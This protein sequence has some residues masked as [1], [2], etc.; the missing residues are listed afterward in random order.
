MILPCKRKSTDKIAGYA[1]KEPVVIPTDTLYGLSMSI[2]GPI[3]RIFELK[4]RN[5]INKIP[6]GVLN[7]DM[8]RKIAYVSP[9][10]IK[11]VHEFMP[12]PLTIVLESKIPQITGETVGVRIPNHVIPLWLM[13]KIGPV[14]L[15]SANIS[16]ET[17]PRK[18]EDTMHL[19]VKYRINC[20]ALPGIPSTV[21]S[22]VN[23]V[24]LIRDGAIPF[25]AILKILE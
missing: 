1:R 24:N 3:N 8:M 20:G 5:P 22:L 9:R 23:G 19:D 6:V 4:K 11:I 25:S 15:T 21:I 13:E 17:A 12:G 10:D 14:T 7:L 18:I 16:G 2:Y